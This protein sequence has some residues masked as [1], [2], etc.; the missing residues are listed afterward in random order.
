M[1]KRNLFFTLSTAILFFTCFCSCKKDDSQGGESLSTISKMQE[2]GPWRTQELSDT[3]GSP[4]YNRYYI[5]YTF[6]GLNCQCIK[7]EYI[8]LP[9][10]TT[11]AVNEA[12]IYGND[13]EVD[14]KVSSICNENNLDAILKTLNVNQTK[15]SFQFLNPADQ[16]EIYGTVEC[17]PL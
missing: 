14:F 17:T 15:L 16:S 1:K 2:Y 10:D 3:L 12:C 13:N 7:E 5:I 6:T 9:S 8:N 11:I 4:E